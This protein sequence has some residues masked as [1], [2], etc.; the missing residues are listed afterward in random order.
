MCTSTCLT[1]DHKTWGECVRAKNLRIAYCRSSVG[2][3]FSAQKTWDSEL[4]AYSSARKQGIQ[5]DS[6]KMPDIRRAVELSDMTGEAYGHSGGA[7]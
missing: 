4:D 1:G 3:D 6:T 2:S 7:E 5:P